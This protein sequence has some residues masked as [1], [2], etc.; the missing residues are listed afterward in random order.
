MCPGSGQSSASN[1][2][3]ADGECLA[4]TTAWLLALV[5]WGQ[6]PCAVHVK[7]PSP[8]AICYFSFAECFLP[9]LGFTSLETLV[10]K[11]I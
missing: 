2:S 9:E 3:P 5:S 1:S 6:K 7:C 11:G 8:L 10:L 4:K